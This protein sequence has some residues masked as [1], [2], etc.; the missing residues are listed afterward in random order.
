MQIIFS[1]MHY[2][3]PHSMHY[4]ACARARLHSFRSEIYS[5]LILR[6]IKASAQQNLI[7]QFNTHTHTK[8]DEI[9]CCFRKKTKEKKNLLL[10]AYESSNEIYLDRSKIYSTNVITFHM[11]CRYSIVCISYVCVCVIWIKRDVARKKIWNDVTFASQKLIEYKTKVK[12]QHAINIIIICWIRIGIVY[13]HKAQAPNVYCQWLNKYIFR[14]L[15]KTNDAVKCILWIQ[16]IR[17][18]AIRSCCNSMP[19]QCDSIQFP[20]HRFKLYL[21]RVWFTWIFQ[22]SSHQNI[23]DRDFIRF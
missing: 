22:C 18:L 15:C 16:T 12:S 4:D 5:I 17:F 14:L 9:V 20:I 11:R 3:Y 8:W 21:L 23:D 19:W 7:K 10:N 13:V 1:S 6:V 2:P